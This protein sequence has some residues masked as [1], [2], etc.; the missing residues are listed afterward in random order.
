MI[1]SDAVRQ[2]E[3]EQAVQVAT[4]ALLRADVSTARNTAKVLRESGEFERSRWLEGEIERAQRAR[5][6][7][8]GEADRRESFQRA[9]A[10]HRF[11][12]AERE[13][14]GLQA[15]G[16][17]RVSVDALRAALDE[18]RGVVRVA[19]TIARGERL[20]SD[21][22]A[23]R[24]WNGAREVVNGLADTV[25]DNPIVGQLL[26]ELVRRE[27]AMRKQT[28]IDQGVAQADALISQNNPADAELALRIL[29]KLDP[30]NPNRKRL[31]K[32]IEALWRV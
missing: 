5:D 12:E 24:D 4:E 28:A 13:L 19:D 7:Q 6:T 21:R 16:V 32:Q 15:L 30:Q 29:L 27:E 2:K 14:D 17:T 10:A 8:R 18:E 11:E 9:L 3:L 22:V 26:N 25:P 1:E 31:E 20:F 23:K